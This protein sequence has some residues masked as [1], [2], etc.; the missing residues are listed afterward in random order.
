[1]ARNRRRDDVESVG[2]VSAVRS[3]IG[4]WAE[5]LQELDDGA[6]PAMSEDQRYGVGLG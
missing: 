4:E 3:G 1:V 2:R 6:G 5:D